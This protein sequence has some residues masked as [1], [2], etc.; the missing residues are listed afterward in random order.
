MDRK[1]CLIMKKIFCFFLSMFL[2]LNI[3]N[4]DILRINSSAENNVSEYATV[5]VITNNISEKIVEGAQIGADIKEKKIILIKKDNR[6]YMS[7]DDICGFTRTN[8]EKT[9]NKYIL[10]QGK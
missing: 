1:E 5:K 9:D 7:L 6:I 3:V 8:K 4:M 10:R 2:L